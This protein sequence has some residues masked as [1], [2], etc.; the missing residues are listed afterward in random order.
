MACVDLPATAA[1]V[2]NG[3]LQSSQARML[4][5]EGLSSAWL[6]LRKEGLAERADPPQFFSMA[7]AISPAAAT[8][9]SGCFQTA[10]ETPMKSAPRRA[11]F[12]TVAMS[13][14]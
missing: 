8:L 5:A 11:S 7:A 13:S 6:R 10:L 12:L 3:R 9:P 4:F 14:A 2:R 1:A